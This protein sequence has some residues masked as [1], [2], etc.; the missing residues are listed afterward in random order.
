MQYRDA[1]S[2]YVIDETTG[3]RQLV[4]TPTIIVDYEWR[5]I[6]ERFEYWRQARAWPRY[7]F[8]DG[9]YR[10]LPRTLRKLD[11]ACPWAHPSSH[12][13]AKEQRK[14]APP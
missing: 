3:V 14:E 12:A 4:E 7:D 11:A 6:D 13:E 1:S 2:R 8:N 10:G 5:R 9:Q